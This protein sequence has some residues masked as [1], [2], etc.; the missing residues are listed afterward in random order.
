MALAGSMRPWLGSADEPE[1]PR[2]GQ[3][4]SE[5]WQWKANGDYSVG[6]EEEVMLLDPVAEWELATRAGEVLSSARGDLSD[7]LDDETQDAV[8]ELA[9][10]PHP[11]AVQAGAQAGELRR[12]LARRLN[13]MGLQAAAAGTHPS[14]V[15][16]EIQIAAGDRHQAVYESMREL[17]RREPTFGLHVHV[18]VSDPQRAM[19]LYNRLRTHLPLLL[20][21]SANSPFWQG[22]DTGM[23]SARTSIF[24]A[25]PRV[26][27]PRAFDSYERW[28]AVVDR[29]LCCG[30]F[31]E[32]THL[33]W[34]IRPQPKFGTIEI[35]IMDA[36]SDS[37]A[38][39]ALAALVQ[40]IAHLELEEGFRRDPLAEEV[41]ILTENRFIAARDGM[42]GLFLDPANAGRI[43]ARHLLSELLDAAAPHA[44]Q[45]GCS[46]ELQVVREL[47]AHGGATRQRRARGDA[48]SLAA[49]TA[50]LARRF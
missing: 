18:G 48:D 37:K 33:W 32:P 47:A 31:P 50:D 11:G 30:A 27:V 1:S 6:L 38:T 3:A 42:D 45:L 39:T 19:A 21:L 7:R 20:A 25:F 15:W 28:V 43:K 26:G 46:D 29:L 4:M 2:D 49:V 40:S 10:E 44:E 5:W 9:T 23:A 35:R 16:T 22:R 34:D 13:D 24:Q 36:Q 41:E 17:A 8:V 12:A 14:A